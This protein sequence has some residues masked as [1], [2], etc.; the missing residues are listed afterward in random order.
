M[1]MDEPLTHVTIVGGG[2]AGWMTAIML[3][4]RLD[5]K[6][7]GPPIKISLIESANVGIIG[8]GEG[9]FPGFVSEIKALG[10]PESDFMRRCNASF[11]LGVRFVNWNGTPQGSINF[12]NPF[13]TEGRINDMN[14]LRYYLAFGPHPGCDPHD[15]SDSVSIISRAIELQRGP[16][17]LAGSGG[18][19]LE[20]RLE[21]RLSRFGYHFDATKLAE[22]LK[23]L[24]VQRGVEHIVDDVDDATVT[25]GDIITHLHL[26]QRG[27][28][29][30]ELVIDCSGFKG[31]L[32]SKVLKEPFK[33]YSKSLLC[34]RAMVLQVPHEDPTAVQP[35][36]TAT[37][38]SA[39][40][41]FALPLFHR[42]GTGY[43]YSSAFRTDEQAAVEYCRHLG[44]DPDKAQP[45]M[46]PMRVGRSHR[47][48]V[49]NCIAIG[50][51][52]GFIEPLEATAIMS[53]QVAVD[54]LWRD[55]PNRSMPR[56]LRD[57]FNLHIGQV[58][59]RV[60]DFITMHYY[61]SNRNEPFWRAARAP[62][63]LTDPLAG[64][65]EAWRYR[66]PHRE[67]LPFPDLFSDAAY[68]SV[69]TSKG[70]YRGHKPVVQPRLDVADWRSVGDR[71][72]GAKAQ[73]RRMPSVRELLVQIRGGSPEAGRGVRTL[74]MA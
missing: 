63:V 41:S 39:G 68:S 5:G 73:L 27:R 36:T 24:A 31:L 74:A 32:I 14:P 42:V 45:R 21:S 71:L 65:L 57:R 20:R 48:W 34:D 72:A 51:S 58:Q 35:C 17:T 37:A 40:W 29:P 23:E 3:R 11:K 61:L 44:V 7:I 18:T 38:L 1:T 49:G 67:D 13:N 9:T 69:I 47:A 6:R 55:F 54:R 50:L 56:G 59:D 26:R 43:V 53:I 10:I 15:F 8:V 46:I 28:F 52:G 22:Y 16:R 70:F 64:N 2:T 60:R 19:E 30:V 66:V 62:E 12:V 25:E 4:G 33:S